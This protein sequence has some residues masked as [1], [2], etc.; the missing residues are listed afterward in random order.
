MSYLVRG[1]GGTEARINGQVDHC[2]RRCAGPSGVLPTEKPAF[3]GSGLAGEIGAVAYMIG[4]AYQAHFTV[5]AA[6]RLESIPSLLLQSESR[7]RACG[8]CG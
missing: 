1:N 2:N 8:Q 3:G 7:R 4:I 6:E 5:N